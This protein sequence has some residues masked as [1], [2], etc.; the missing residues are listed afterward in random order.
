MFQ[1]IFSCFLPT[2]FVCVL[3]Q[4]VRI[5]EVI[6]LTIYSSQSFVWKAEKNKI[7]FPIGFL[8]LFHEVIL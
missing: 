1:F 5:L 3:D 2:V 8:E 6:V 4:Y 7:V